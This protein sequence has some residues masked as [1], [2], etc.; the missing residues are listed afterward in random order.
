MDAFHCMHIKIFKVEH[1]CTAFV[2]FFVNYIV[3]EASGDFGFWKIGSKLN[4]IGF[5]KLKPLLYEINQKL[6]VL[7]LIWVLSACSAQTCCM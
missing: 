6:I 3:E 7:G 4:L 1:I 5:C 2:A